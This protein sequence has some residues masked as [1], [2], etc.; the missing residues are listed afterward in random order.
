MFGKKDS[1]PLEVPKD[2]RITT[3]PQDFYAG[4]DPTV[5]FKETEKIVDMAKLSG[6][7]LKGHEK[8]AL[9]AATAKGVA[10]ISTK[11]WIVGAAGLFVIFLV[12]AGIYYWLTLRTKTEAVP[13][14]PPQIITPVPPVTPTPTPTE[15]EA[16]S[17]PTT[18]PETPPES[19][20][21][22]ELPSKLL[23]FAA[24]MDGDGISDAAEIVFKS[25]PGNP[26][27][28]NDFYPDGHEIFYL[29]NPNGFEPVKLIES[30]VVKLF[31]SGNFNYELYY[32]ESWAVGSVDG[33]GR[34]VLFSTL[35]G[36][37]IEV[38]VFDKEFGLSPMNWFS[39]NA[40]LSEQFSDYRDFSSRFAVA[41]KVRTDGLVYFFFT[42]DK[43]YAI[44]YHVTNSD[45][46]NYKS[47]IDIMARSF[48][49]NASGEERPDMTPEFAPVP[50]INAPVTEVI[51]P[52]PTTT[53]MEEEMTDEIIE[54]LTEETNE[55]S[56]E[57]ITE[58]I[59][60]EES[61]GV[62]EEDVLF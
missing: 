47:V 15:P 56:S 60:P 14:T 58:E 32:P 41:G 34:Q 6:S 26:D 31:K 16:T 23:S 59:I 19:P 51:P 45:T 1:N 24:D 22:M 49:I 18:T 50:T 37:N 27:T 62:S 36:E 17:T 57:E 12:G 55:E 2:L 25:D 30:G 20:S 52:A 7:P 10:L 35:T 3:I 38:R 21:G 48:Y 4:A 54:E 5:K 46:V 43:V 9:D 42:N 11:W 29:Y 28:D 13:P 53:S 61:E 39:A 8:R 40:P 44:I 33:E